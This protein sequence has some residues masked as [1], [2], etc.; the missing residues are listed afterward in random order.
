MGTVLL[1]NEK[2]KRET[3]KEKANNSREKAEDGSTQY[4]VSP[5]SGDRQTTGEGQKT[6]CAWLELS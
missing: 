4:A 3:S 6:F 2:N 1:P 5:V